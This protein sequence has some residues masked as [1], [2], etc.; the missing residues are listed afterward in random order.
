[1][2]RLHISR[3][4]YTASYGGRCER[5][6]PEPDETPVAACGGDGPV[7]RRGHGAALL[8]ENAFSAEFH[9]SECISILRGGDRS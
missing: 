6:L 2:N 4:F 9:C 7:I 3:Q 8:H 5:W 1:M